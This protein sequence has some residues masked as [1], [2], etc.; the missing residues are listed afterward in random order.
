VEVIGAEAA[1]EHVLERYNSRRA[2]G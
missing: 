2:L 1:V